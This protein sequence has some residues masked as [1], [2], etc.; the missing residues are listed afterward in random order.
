MNDDEK[1]SEWTNYSNY[2]SPD[3]RDKKNE[4]SIALGHPREIGLLSRLRTVPESRRGRISVSGS[5]GDEKNGGE[6]GRGKGS[7]IGPFVRQM[8]S[9]V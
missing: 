1:F 6:G 8:R 9:L 7:I 5:R 2:P 3:Q 4:K